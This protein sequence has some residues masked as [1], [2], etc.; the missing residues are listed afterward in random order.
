MYDTAVV[1]DRHV[2]SNCDTN[3]EHNVSPNNQ[4]NYIRTESYGC[5]K[6]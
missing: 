3:I 2:S 4:H 6:S 1:N 5:H